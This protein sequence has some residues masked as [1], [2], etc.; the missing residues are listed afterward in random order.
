MFNEGALLTTD[1]KEDIEMEDS[2]DL[3]YRSGDDILF[4]LE[5]I[6]RKNKNEEEAFLSI[7]ILSAFLP[8]IEYY[9]DEE[10][11]MLTESSFKDLLTVDEVLALVSDLEAV[12]SEYAEMSRNIVGVLVNDFRLPLEALSG[13]DRSNPKFDLLR[14]A[15]LNCQLA[16]SQIVTD[17]RMR[18]MSLRMSPEDLKWFNHYLPYDSEILDD[19]GWGGI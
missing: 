13:E 18:S 3:F 6:I 12:P 19:E 16:V 7:S 17:S 14:K 9:R 10:D 2:P 11:M 8:V 4:A 15:L 5:P 1:L